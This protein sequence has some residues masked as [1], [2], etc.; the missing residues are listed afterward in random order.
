M[1]GNVITASRM[2]CEELSSNFDDLATQYAFP[3]SQTRGSADPGSLL[4]V[5]TTASYDLSTGLPFLVTDANG[6]PTQTAYFP[7]SLR[8]R[9]IILPTGARIAFE[10]DDA[11]M[12]VVETRRLSATGTI[13]SQTTKHFNGLGQVKKEEALGTGGV[14]DTVE[15]LYDQFGRPSKQSLPYRSGQTPQWRETI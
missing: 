10:Y 9:E 3:V 14:V 2:C 5:T 6:R 7:T 12:K 11:A 15:T 1:A 4:R 13:A 8:P